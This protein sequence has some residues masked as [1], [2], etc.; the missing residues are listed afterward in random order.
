M[1]VVATKTASRAGKNLRVIERLLIEYGLAGSGRA[2]FAP[3]RQVRR[4]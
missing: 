2:L 3:L 1:T 4:K